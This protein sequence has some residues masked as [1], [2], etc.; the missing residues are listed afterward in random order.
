LLLPAHCAVQSEAI[1]HRKSLAVL[2]SFRM[3]IGSAW[4]ISGF[5]MAVLLG[6]LLGMVVPPLQRWTNEY[7]RA[8]TFYHF[9]D[10]GS[11]MRVEGVIKATEGGRLRYPAN[12]FTARCER[13][14]CTWTL[15]FI[16]GAC[17]GSPAIDMGQGADSPIEF[18]ANRIVFREES[19]GPLAFLTGGEH[20]IVTISV[21]RL[22]KSVV[23][24]GQRSEDPVPT[25]RMILSG[26]ESGTC[27]ALP[28]RTIFDGLLHR[29]IWSD[30]SP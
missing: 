22:A 17:S 3:K 14:L 12:A 10:D 21:D 9:Y 26:G 18:S 28:P 27:P 4:L 19:T 5:A 2:Q 15:S 30:N 7:W 20:N 8:Q 24:L 25:L 29:N 6:Y 16:R 11:H 13:G 1:G 23:L